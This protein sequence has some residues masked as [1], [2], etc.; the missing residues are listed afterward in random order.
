MKWW[1]LRCE[2]RSVRLRRFGS[3][4]KVEWGEGGGQAGFRAMTPTAKATRL[5]QCGE[6]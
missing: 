3:D 6:A 4:W 2:A 1:L 5:I